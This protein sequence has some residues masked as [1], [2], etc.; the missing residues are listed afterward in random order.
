MSETANTNTFD[1]EALPITI[2]YAGETVR[3]D[4]DWKCDEWRVIFTRDNNSWTTSYYTGLGLRSPIP[5]L[6]LSINPPRKGTVAYEQLEKA[7][8]KPMTPKKADVLYALF[9]DATAADYNFDDWCD[10][11][12]YSSDSIKALNV[13][14]ECLETAQRLRRYFNTEQ[15]KAI[16]EI[17]SEM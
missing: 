1:I 3:G 14:K 5:A 8:R 2:K 17:I 10:S 12:G 13:Y 6:Y 15:R 9:M 4:N 11:Y 16:E 7:T